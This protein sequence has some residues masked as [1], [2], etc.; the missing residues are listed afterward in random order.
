MTDGIYLLL[1]TNLGDKNINLKAAISIISTFSEVVN[2]SA[3]Y[4]TAAWGKTDQPSFYNQVIEIRT[5]LSPE[6]LLAELLKTEKSLGRV[7]IEKW[8]ER[9]IDID[10]LYYNQ[11]SINQEGLII[12]HPGIPDRRFTLVPLCELAPEFVNP[13]NGLTNA[14]MLENLHDQLSVKK[15]T[16]QPS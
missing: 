4:E 15:L 11:T 3:I 5:D 6:A 7:R 2:Q 1:G 8:G 13:A 16:M 10:I 9:L 14:K 12:P